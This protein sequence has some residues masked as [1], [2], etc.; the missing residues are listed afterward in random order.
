MDDFR[1]NQ[2]VYDP[3]ENNITT[4]NLTKWGPVTVK[5]SQEEQHV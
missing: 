4:L 1:I 5:V 3:I 2:P